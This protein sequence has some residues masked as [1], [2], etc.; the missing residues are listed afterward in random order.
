MTAD[1]ENELNSIRDRYARRGAVSAR[2]RRFYRR[3]QM[4]RERAYLRLLH[5]HFGKSCEQL[6]VLEVGAGTGANLPFFHD[7]MGIPWENI[8]AN[9]LLDDRADLLRANVPGVRVISGNALCIPQAETF[10]VVLA[11]TV[12]TSILDQRLRHALASHLLSIASSRGVVLW[13]DFMYDN[14]WNKDVR[15]VPL[16]EL[17]RLFQGASS[18]K[19]VTI[20][21]APPVGRRIG[22]LYSMLSWIPILHTHV[23]AVVKK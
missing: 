14:P 17:R 19:T 1:F 9:E 6:H 3:I 7:K 10:D 12:F 23:V 13:Y 21:L 4:E 2:E 5:G 18:I 20:T 22:P 11:S 8:V 16:S 15:G